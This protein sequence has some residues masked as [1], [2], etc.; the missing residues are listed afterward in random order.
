MMSKSE[1]L[2]V[3]PWLLNQLRM[4]WITRCIRPILDMPRSAMFATISFAL[5]SGD[6]PGCVRSTLAAISL[7]RLEVFSKFWTFLTNSAISFGP[8]ISSKRAWPTASCANTSCTLLSFGRLSAIR[9]TVL[10]DSHIPSTSAGAVLSG[11]SSTDWRTLT[12]IPFIGTTCASTAATVWPP[13][14]GPRD[15]KPFLLSL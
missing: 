3:Y 1:K 2:I 15:A 9:Y 6:K 5:R 11:N 10:P 7:T 4:A 8:N 14:A 13:S 12:V